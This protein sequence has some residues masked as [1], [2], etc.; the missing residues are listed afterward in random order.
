MDFSVW[1]NMS[2]PVEEILD[3]ARWLDAGEWHG[4]WFADHYMGNTCLLYTSD[5][6]DE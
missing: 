3:L 4:F 1:P 5:A 6:A 2:Y